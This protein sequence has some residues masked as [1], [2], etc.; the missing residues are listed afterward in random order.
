MVLFY[1]L[2]FKDNGCKRKKGSEQKII[3][4][5]TYISPETVIVKYGEV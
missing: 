2:F 1:T 3:L 5:R 4:S